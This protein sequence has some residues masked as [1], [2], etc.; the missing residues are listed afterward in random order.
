MSCEHVIFIVGPTAVGKTEV[1]CLLAEQLGAEIV[2]CDA[3]QVYRDVD[4][5]TNKPSRDILARIPHHLIDVRDVEEEFDVAAYNDLARQAIRDIHSRRKTAIVTG[6]SGLYMQVLLDG[7]FQG[8]PKQ[9]HLRDELWQCWESEGAGV[10]FKELEER[11]PVATRKIHPHDVRRIIRALEICRSM[12][13]PFSQ[14]Q[15]ERAGLWAGRHGLTLIALNRPREALYGRIHARTDDMFQEGLVEEIRRLLRRSLSPTA[16]R[17]I[18]VSEV[19]GYLN[20]EY[21]ED[22]A[23]YLMKLHTRH[24][25]KRQ[26]TWFRKERRLQWVDIRE[27]MTARD[28]TEHIRTAVCPPDGR[29]AEN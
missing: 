10:L 15:Q 12:A 4:I 3:M 17:I 16:R 27:G 9:Q 26:L 1:A 14:L 28:V 7:I 19:A 23:R 21:G 6:G 5:A 11:D 25:A 18:G 20:R 29:K 13:K 8:A 2:S 24:Y 22:R